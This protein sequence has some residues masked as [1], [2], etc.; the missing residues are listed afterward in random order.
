VCCF[1]RPVEHVS[2]TRIFA[3]PAPGGRQVLAYS[4]NVAVAEELAMVLPIPVP[5]D[6][7]DEAVRFIDLSGYASFFRDLAK[8]FPVAK[9]AKSFGRLAPAGRA[10]RPTLAVHRVGEF[11]ASFVPTR[12]DF[13]RLD[14][15]FR[16]PDAT[17]ASLA[18][19]DE[20]GFC[21]FKLRPRRGLFAR[22][23][24]MQSIHPM[25]FDFPRRDSDVLFFPTLHIHDGEVHE[26]AFFDHELYC[27]PAP[28][29]AELLDWERSTAPVGRWVDPQRAADLVDGDAH[30]FRERLHGPLRN[31]DQT[32][33]GRLIRATVRLGPSSLLRVAPFAGPPGDAARP[34]REARATAVSAA[35]DRLLDAE[36][37]AW[38]LVRYEVDL[39]KHYP[40]STTPITVPEGVLV[41]VPPPPGPCR[42][43]LY[44][45]ADDP[46]DAVTVE[47]AFADCPSRDAF[48]RVE[49]RVVEAIRTDGTRE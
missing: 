11:E 47:L 8:A 40:V 3:R 31:A 22:F 27:Q 32:V 34:R 13:D 37:A 25:A 39:P 4:M 10:G 44:Y 1:S 28:E 45:G 5:P 36:G 9:P 17:W 24:R 14:P 7:G 30:V 15:R 35:V 12:G 38:G 19:Y 21:V 29:L 23:R 42:V 16:L 43:S 6:A 2:A 46:E 20:W 49:R 26:T 41:P 48:E 18:R 33:D